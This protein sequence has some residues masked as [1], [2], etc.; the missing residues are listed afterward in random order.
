MKII[1]V[2]IFLN[3]LV[4]LAWMKASG[5]PEQLAWMNS[6]FLVSGESLRDGR[7]W[8][9]ISSAFSHSLL[10]HIVLNMMVL[11]SFGPVIESILGI[12]R[13]LNFY[14]VAAIVSS[15]S[16][17]LVSTYI[18]GDPDIPALGASGSVS[19]IIILFSLLFPK[20]KLLLFGIIPMPAFIGA[21][22]FVGLDI[23]GV[24]AQADGGG[25]PIGHGAHLGGAFTGL[26]YYFIFR[27][28]AKSIYLDRHI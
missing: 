24:I 20:E 7:Y 13:F 1:H 18:M 15:I 11:N 21:L 19:G 6:N 12:T 16:H 26:I 4:F 3:V 22:A 25:L 14:F 5:S 17:V 9:L 28:R 8:T 2:I 10:L 23:W 27:K